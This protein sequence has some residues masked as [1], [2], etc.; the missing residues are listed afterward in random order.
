MSRFA[1][2]KADLTWESEMSGEIKDAYPVGEGASSVL[3]VI[4]HFIPE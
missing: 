1:G 3:Q 4:N 2:D